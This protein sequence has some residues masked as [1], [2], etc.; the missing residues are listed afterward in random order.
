M[1]YRAL[2]QITAQYVLI[3]QVFYKQVENSI[4][5]QRYFSHA[6]KIVMKKLV[7]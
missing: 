7:S 2:A 5:Y 4:D 3:A 6:E 1:A